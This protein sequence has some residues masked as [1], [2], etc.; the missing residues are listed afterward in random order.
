MN[1]SN[2]PKLLKNKSHNSKHNSKRNIKSTFR[3]KKCS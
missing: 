1:N 3:K 2:I